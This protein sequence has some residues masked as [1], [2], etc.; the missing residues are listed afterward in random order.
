MWIPAQSDWW[1]G[2]CDNEDGAKG[3]RWHQAVITNS[4]KLARASLLGFASDRGV[5]LNKGR[6]GAKQGPAALRK[7]LAN[8]A[9]HHQ[10]TGIND[11]GDILVD[12][13]LPA[14]QQAYAAALC[15][16]L[17]AGQFVLGL[18]G[19]HEIGWPGFLGCQQ[20]IQHHSPG[21]SLGIINFDA[22]FDLRKPAPAASSGTPFLQA[23]DYCQQQQLNFSYACLG[24]ARSANTAILYERAK[25]LNVAYIEDLAFSNK[26]AITLLDSFLQNQDYLYVTCCL[27]VF[28]AAD[29]PGVSAPAALG[30]SPQ[31][32]LQ[33]IAQL[34]ELCSKHQ[35]NWLYADVA[36]LSPPHD[37]DDR[38]A[39][40]AARI[41]DQFLHARL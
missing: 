39:R 34:G 6:P 16:A 5:M 22:H 8:L 17:Q 10:N 30:I 3:K 38:S 41:I 40:L 15:Q 13:D 21:K 7:A 12:D 19:G 4:D 27:D 1:Q 35:V 31:L 26:N 32:V 2:R 11:R 24:V 29:A 14:G 36:E 20:F 9:W 28:P 33:L 25:T 23:A 18:G 37:I